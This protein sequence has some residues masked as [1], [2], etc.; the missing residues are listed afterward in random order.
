M[1]K[2]DVQTEFEQLLAIHRELIIRL[3]AWED[4]WIITQAIALRAHEI[5]LRARIT[6][7]EPK[8]RMEALQKTEHIAR[9]VTFGVAI[10]PTTL[11]LVMRTI[12][13]FL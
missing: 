9:L 2:D 3:H 10:D 11:R 8:N 5:Q 4:R 12:A 7:F 1:R 6:A 13:D